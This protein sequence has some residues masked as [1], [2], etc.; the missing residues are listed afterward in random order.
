MNIIIFEN[1]NVSQLYP[2]TLTRPSFSIL[3]GATTLH[4]LFK[5]ELRPTTI[6]FLVRAELTKITQERFANRPAI[7]TKFLLLDGALVPSV[8]ILPGLRKIVTTGKS[9]IFKNKKDTLGAYLD[10]SELG[11]KIKDLHAIKQSTAGAFITDL[12]LKFQLVSWQKFEQP[13][14][15]IDYNEQI[16]RENLND[17]KKDFKQYQPNVFVGKGV[18][19]EPPVSFDTS[20][21]PVVINDRSHVKSMAALRGPLYIGKDCVI[22]GFAD[23]KHGTCIGDVCKVGGEVEASVLQG[24][25]NK[26]HLGFLGG[27]YVGEWVNLGAGTSNS[28]LKNTYGSIKMQG[29]PTGKQFLGCVIGDYT[30]AAIGT[31]IFTGKVV[32]VSSFLYGAITTDVPS[33]TNAG[34]L[35]KRWV[36][37]PLKL[38]Q[39]IQQAI[40]NRRKIKVTA[41][42]RQLLATVFNLTTRDR[43]LASVAA[44]AL[45]LK[46]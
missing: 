18:V 30:K 5:K 6:N 33:F 45:E 22:N 20:A 24:Y 14:Q 44:G 13:W 37:C 39:V 23:I 1:Q 41:A 35:L 11:L 16:L 3:C 17:F 7:G 46:R 27:S 15:V 31:S 2:I 25:A 26:Q 12:K 19:I 34:T 29:Q 40:F 36:V 42:D 32:G 21:G 8:N 10:L 4:D 38:A 9:V 28:D 43:K